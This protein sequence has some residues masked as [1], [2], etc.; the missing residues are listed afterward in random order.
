MRR[1]FRLP[2]GLLACLFSILAQ[3]AQPENGANPNQIALLRW[4]PANRVTSFATGD[5]PAGLAFDG[6][7]LWIA[8]AYSNTITQLRASNG[9]VIGTYPTGS[10]PC[11]VA[12]DGAHI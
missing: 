8:D 11:G 7:S 4:Y 12:F 6:D 1:I 10:W 5:A 3:T 2:L 9:S